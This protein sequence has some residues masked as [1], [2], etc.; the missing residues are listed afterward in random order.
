M[1]NEKNDYEKKVLEQLKKFGGSAK[2]FDDLYRPLKKYMRKGDLDRALGAL[3]RQNKVVYSNPGYAIVSKKNLIPCTVSRLKKTFGFVRSDADDKEYFV[4]GRYLNGAMPGDKVLVQT[5]VGR[6]DLIEGKVVEITE[7]N[8]SRFTGNIVNEFGEL[9][10]VPDTLSK[11]A[12]KIEDA[13][14]FKLREGD[15]VLAE[16]CHRGRSH[17]DHKCRIIAS[18][19]SSLKA[20]VCAMSVLE[21]NGLTPIFPP[22]V[23]AEA[24]AVSDQRSV[25]AEL[26]H[27]LDLRGLPI[28]TIDGAA[29][30]DIDDAISV[31]KTE[32]G[33]KLG[34]HIADVSHYVKPKSE[35]DNEAFKRGTSVYYANRVIPMLPKELSN[36][37]CSLNPQEDRLAFSAL[38][39]LDRDANIVSYKFAKT[40]I[41][42]RVKGVYSEINELLEG[43][44]SKALC[45]KYAEVLDVIPVMNELAQ[46]L[47]GKKIYRGAPQISTVESELIINDEDYCVDVKPHESGISQEIIEDFMLCANECAA[48]FGSEN[49]L[50]FV[51]RIHEDPPAERVETLKMG[52][53]ELNIPYNFDE[54]VN[55]R[56]LSQILEGVRGTDK[57]PVVN[58]LVLRSMAKAKYSAEPVGHFGLVLADYAHFTSPIRRY[59]D[60]A[61]HR[62]MSDFLAGGSDAKCRERYS[63]FAY[64]AADHA[65]ETEIIAMQTERGCE[66][67]YKAE[68]M[69]SKLGEVYEGVV[70]SC[71]PHGMYVLLDNSC[72][73]LVK[74]D[75][76]PWQD[77]YYD[78]KFSIKR[79]GGGEQFTVGKR[80]KIRV[81]AADVSSGNVDFDYIAPAES[82]KDA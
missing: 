38:M 44:N 74:M 78:E 55:P 14:D 79:E 7:E 13:G 58:N 63:K 77:Y 71:V 67:C 34:V 12:M 15:K 48:K 80:I 61:I 70:V 43:Y 51:Y 1:K 68:F 66:D 18:F 29:T 47:R 11:Y 60:L 3:E 46:K 75:S 73:G 53:T 5:Y 20:S 33:Y 28:F 81:T 40:V 42:S 26:P 76:L 59:P 69:K 32:S 4:A 82:R 8:F 16:V 52:L 35:L 65:T 64:A 41:R 17:A 22:E 2:S 19:G 45:E 31:E 6:N 21:L 50:P 9:K 37:I 24:K 57:F 39:E 23:I 62:I 49:G 54:G 25:S 10:L 36:G 56:T 27:R 30:K 72:E